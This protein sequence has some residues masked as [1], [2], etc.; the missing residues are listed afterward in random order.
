MNKHDGNKSDTDIIISDMSRCE[1]ASAFSR[2]ASRNR[3]Q[4]L[5]YRACD[6]KPQS[7]LMFGAPSYVAAPEVTMPLNVSGWHAVSIG[8]WIPR[9]DYD[10]AT[11]VK[12]KFDND[13][14][15]SRISEPEPVPGNEPKDGAS[16]L[17]EAYFKT[18]D[19][20]GRSL[21]F[22]KV[23]GLFAQKAYMAYVRLAPIDNAAAEALQADMTSVDTRT[24]QAT[25]DGTSF[26]CS[27]EYLTRE[28][29]LELVE[30]YRYSDVGKVTWAFCYGETTNYP[31]KVGTYVA[32]C[33]NSR[34]KISL[35][36]NPHQ[37]GMATIQDSLSR[38]GAK[39]I[40]PQ[41]VA[42]EHVHKM[43]LK[44][45]AMFRLGIAGNL[46][47]RPL[48]GLFAGEFVR[49]NPQFRLAM[50]DGTPV[51]KASYA[52]PEVRALMLGIIRE[53]AEMFD[54]D[55]AS[56]AFNRGPLF[57][58]YEQPVLEDF[59]KEFNVDARSVTFDDPRLQQ[60]HS[61]YLNTF[62]RDAR[63][64]LDEVGA[65]KGKRLELSVWYEGQTRA[66]RM[67]YGIDVET[68]IREG[69]LDSVVGFAGN[70]GMDPSIISAANT[71]GCRCIPGLVCSG[72]TQHEYR[73]NLLNGAD[74]FL[75]P[76]GADGIAL[77]DSDT[78]TAG[79]IWPAIRRMGH[80]DEFS[81]FLKTPYERPFIAL[82]DVDGCNMETE[83]GRFGLGQAAYSCG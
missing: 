16:L 44:F 37:M 61:R 63:K 58:A 27:N 40:I 79:G 13:P 14:C 5:A 65:A 50:S 24:V 20:T 80:R 38:L 60:I 2:R 23:G 8:F 75:Y 57:A 30:P 21:V 67:R 59:R 19:L 4:L 25:I 11:T 32:R 48:T 52:F 56:L 83:N 76:D 31:S 12:V 62:V 54:I 43:G 22:G 66:E 53:S 36:N 73:K 17:K 15:F 18:A 7:G 81:A 3:W 39:G 28:H 74:K 78:L 35:G 82:K 10:G 34:K 51:E 49:A 72:G 41:A 77:W 71:H 70:V 45:E 42:A 55:G 1:P 69:L 6:S 64:V 33:D 9:H 46:P 47:P 68:W 29:I 26:F